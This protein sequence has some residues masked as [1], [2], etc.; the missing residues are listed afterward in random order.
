M[1][2]FT[3]IETQEQFNEAIK[4]RL[5]R[6]EKKWQEKYSGYLGPDD[7]AGKTKE[8]EDKI[9][10]LSNSLNSANDKAKAD[11][12]AIAGLEAKVKDYETASVKSRIAHEVGIPFELANKLSGETEKEIRKDAEALKPYVTAHTQPLHDPESGGNSTRE[13]FSTWVEQNMT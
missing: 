11:A 7:L 10:E 5:E 2:D 6:A 4:E 12:E 8:L 9:V 3:P 13:L 1:A